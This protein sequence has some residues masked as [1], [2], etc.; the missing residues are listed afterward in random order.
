[1]PEATTHKSYGY[2]TYSKALVGVTGPQNLTM[3][4]NNNGNI[5]TKS[6]VGTNAYTYDHP[7]KP[8]ALTDIA[9]S[10]GLVSDSLQAI[11]YTSFEQPDTLTE[12]PYKAI[13]NYNREGQRCKMV[14]TQQGTTILT[15]W[16]A[17]NRYMKETEGSTTREYTWV[18]GDAY[19]APVA[20]IT[21]SGTTTYYYLLRDYLGNITHVYNASAG[22]WQEFSFDAW[23]RRRDKDNW[24]YT[25]SG[26]PDL[27][28]GRGF[29]SHEFLPW[30]NL[31]NMNGRMGVYPAECNE[32][33][34]PV[35]G[36]FLSLDNYVQNPDFSQSYNRYSYCLNNPLIYTDYSGN[37]WWNKFW[38]WTR[39]HNLQDLVASS[40]NPCSPF[41]WIASA[42]E[43]INNGDWSKLDPTNPGTKV[44]NS[45]RIFQGLFA[46]DTDKE[47]WGWQIVSRLTWQRLQTE[48]GIVYSNF[49]NLAYDGRRVEFNNGAT[50]LDTRKKPNFTTAITFGSYITGWDITGQRSYLLSHEYGHYLQ[51]QASGPLYLLKYGIPSAIKNSRFDGSEPWYEEDASLRGRAYFRGTY[52]TK[53]FRNPSWWEFGLS[54]TP[55]RYWISIINLIPEL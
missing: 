22:T 17:S 38:D 46:A 11:H 29:T 16:Y 24:G 54:L 23:G 27:F 43:A 39:K 14:A 45:S 28:A 9:T 37:T 12:N 42:V 25:L 6:D 40:Y 47:G 48:I 49:S 32:S 30:F 10:G 51:S 8:Y 3:G 4:Y 20:A 18:G 26:E 55:V 5:E 35:V 13:L 52:K 21:Q 53:D 7:T 15:R 19:T 34:N 36:R 33:G 44:N 50:V 1:M 2:P 31:Y 41:A